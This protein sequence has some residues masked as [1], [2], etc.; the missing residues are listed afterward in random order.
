M[1][2][3]I[4]DPFSPLMTVYTWF[5]LQGRRLI[6]QLAAAAASAAFGRMLIYA[7]CPLMHLRRDLM[8]LTKANRSINIY[9]TCK[10]IR[11]PT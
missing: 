3:N 1:A 8:A 11:P 2:P 10:D 9:Y 6:G 7:F 5:C 4:T